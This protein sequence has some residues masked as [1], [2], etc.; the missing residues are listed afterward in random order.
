MEEATVSIS[1]T[2]RSFWGLEHQQKT[3]GSSHICGTG[4]TCWT[5]VGGEA[6]GPEVIGCPS[7]GKC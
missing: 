5:S 6:L 3:H 7:V 2:P 4:Y 1:Q